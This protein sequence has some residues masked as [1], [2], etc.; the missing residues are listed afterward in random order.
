MGAGSVTVTVRAD[1]KT[2]FESGTLRGG[3]TPVGVDADLSGVRMLEI[4]LGTTEDGAS[5]DMVV[6]ASPWIDYGGEAPPRRPMSPPR[7][8]A[9]QQDEAAVERLGLARSAALP[10][11]KPRPRTARPTTGCF[12]PE[13]SR[14]GI[15]RTPDGKSIVVA[16][17][18]VARTLRIFPN[19]ATTHLTNR[20]TGEKHAASPAARVS[21]QSTAAGGRS[22]AAGQPERAY[23]KPEWIEEMTTLPRLVR[24]GGFPRSAR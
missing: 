12:T 2:V 6:L 9:P 21:S 17:G 20:M 24:G 22:A 14:R 19:L 18:M 13:R 1:G 23:L 10:V 7:A 16:N 3:E 11:W 15:Y 4:V 8:R 5:G